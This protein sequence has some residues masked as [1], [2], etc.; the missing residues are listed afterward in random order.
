MNRSLSRSFIG[1]CLLI[2]VSCEQEPQPIKVIG[3]TVN[4]TSLSLVEGETTDII[5]TVSPKDADNQTVIWSSSDGSVASVNG[6]KVSALKAGTATITAKTDDGGYTASST[7]KVMARTIEVTSISLSKTELTLTEGD[8]ETITAIVAPEDATNK[9]VIWTSSD[10]EVA[11]VDDGLILAI[12]EGG[13]IITATAGDKSATCVVAVKHDTM[14]DAIVFADNNVKAVLV[15]VFD[16]DGDGELSYREAA[17]VNSIDSLFL[18]AVSITSFDEL[19]YFT[20]LSSIGHRTFSG[21]NNL[22]SVVLPNQ[23]TEIGPSAFFRTAFRSI[24]IPESVTTIGTSAFM[25]NEALESMFIPKN[26]S[27]I[28]NELF[29]G[30]INLKTIV[31]D[32]ENNSFDSRNGCNA[33]ISKKDYFDPFYQSVGADVLKN[34]LISGCSETTIP[35]GVEYIRENALGGFPDLYELT[36]PDSVKE[37]EATAFLNDYGLK[38]VQFGKGLRKIGVAAFMACK[39]LNK[40]VL[41]ESLTILEGLVFQGCDKLE[42]V[43]I[44]EGLETIRFGSFQSCV[45]LREVVLPES[46]KKIEIYAFSGCSKLSSVIVNAINPPSIPSNTFNS[47]VPNIYVPVQ[48]VET[49]KTAENWSDYADRIQAIPE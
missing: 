25:Y 15:S 23:I 9:T 38:S 2:M 5:A 18:D 16:S 46:I 4:P 37:I 41:P 45:Y 44:S 42:S 10:T 14:K 20:G 6:G 26:V 27:V 40:V 21:C 43:T 11:T 35:E 19:Q 49:Y 28:G 12:K 34:T 3:I 32:P 30:D 24:V 22:T 31:V 48:S 8:S 39:S 13:V 36:I 1:V 17:S 29:Y 33:I 7:V 47:S